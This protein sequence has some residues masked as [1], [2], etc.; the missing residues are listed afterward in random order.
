LFMVGRVQIGWELSMGGRVQ[1]W[2]GRDGTEW[3]RIVHLGVYCTGYTWF[4]LA[5]WKNVLKGAASNGCRGKGAP[6]RWAHSNTLDQSLRPL[7]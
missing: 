7:E 5:V 4:R 6:G 3:E 1:I 2:L